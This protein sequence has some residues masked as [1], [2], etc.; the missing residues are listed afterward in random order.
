MVAKILKREVFALADLHQQPL[1]Q[2]DGFDRILNLCLVHCCFY[3]CFF[4]DGL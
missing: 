4:D 2:Q 3:L 1:Q